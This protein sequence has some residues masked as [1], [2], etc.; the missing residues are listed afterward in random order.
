MTGGFNAAT[1]TYFETTLSPTSSNSVAL[2]GIS[3]GARSTGTGPTS[4]TIR[5]SIDAFASDLATFTVPN[6]SSYA[7]YSNSLSATGISGQAV[8]L[9][10]YAF[11]GSGSAATNTANFRI[12][13]LTI[14]PTAILPLS[15]TSFNASYNGRSSQL[16]WS[17][18]NESN[19]KGFAIERSV[20]GLIY[21]EFAFVPASNN[22]G[23]TSYSYDDANVNNGA[24][25]YRIKILSNDGSFKYSQVFL[26]NN[27][28]SMQ[29]QVFP[30]PAAN[31]VTI[32]H[33]KAGLRAMLRLVSID[34]R[35]IKAQV[36]PAGSLQSAMQVSELTSGNYML[37]FENNGKKTT[38]KFTKL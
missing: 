21:N 34:G 18:A 11:N 29:L 22:A 4:I 23:Q 38:T 15:L 36:T 17:T 20:D 28:L 16:K 33:G 10:I 25:Y 14:N 32:T 6:N 9:R 30:N 5:S 35:Q 19:I 7:F 31:T 37:I 13:D 1:S 8:I 27:K 2:S 24:N 3:F 26:I 12:D